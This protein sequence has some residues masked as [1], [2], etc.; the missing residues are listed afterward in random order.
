MYQVL[1]GT[2]VSLLEPEK[3]PTPLATQKRLDYTRHAIRAQGVA[4]ETR[5]SLFATAN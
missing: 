3:P 2:Y 4:A 1:T 5:G